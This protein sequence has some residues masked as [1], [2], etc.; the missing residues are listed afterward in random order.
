MMTYHKRHSHTSNGVRTTTT[1]SSNGSY[2]RSTSTGSSN[3][4]ITNTVKSGGQSYTTFTT[5]RSDGSYESKRV[6]SHKHKEPKSSPVYSYSWED[7]EHRRM[8]REKYN[9]SYS[10]EDQDDRG[11]FNELPKFDWYFGPII[12][13]V[14]AVFL[15]VYFTT[16][17]PMMMM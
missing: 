15:V 14:F 10:R 13:T 3:F 12:L 1:N 8:E 5:R 17:L 2:T 7:R 16:I 11:D 9:Q 4:R 6:G